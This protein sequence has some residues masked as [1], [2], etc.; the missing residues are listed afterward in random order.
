MMKRTT[1]AQFERSTGHRV[2]VT[3]GLAAVLKNKFVEGT[4][5]DVLL[6]TSPLIYRTKGLG[7]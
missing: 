7:G 1:L 3:Y 5:A 4:P 6:L 2:A